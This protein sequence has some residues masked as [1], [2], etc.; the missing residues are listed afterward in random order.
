MGLAKCQ[1][2]D[3]RGNIATTITTKYIAIHPTH[4]TVSINHVRFNYTVPIL[5]VRFYYT[6][7]ILQVRF[8]YAVPIL[9]VRF[10][11]T[12]AIH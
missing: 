4:Y 7:A 6:V 9:Q 3:L 2:S 11:H 12:V 10:Y 5:H 1:S 8:N